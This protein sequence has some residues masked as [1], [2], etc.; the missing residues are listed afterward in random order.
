[1]KQKTP[2]GLY[3]PNSLV[4]IDSCHQIKPHQRSRL[5]P[6]EASVTSL[7]KLESLD[8]PTFRA[9]TYK[10]HRQFSSYHGNYAHKFQRQNQNR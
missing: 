7:N 10:D 2:I 5:C 4:Q 8:V 1:M 6:H 9:T 3:R